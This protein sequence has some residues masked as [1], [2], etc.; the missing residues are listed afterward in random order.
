MEDV[1]ESRTL[2]VDLL[3]SMGLEVAEAADGATAVDLWENFAPHLIFMDIR[4]PVLDGYKATRQI[5][6]HPQ[7]ENTIIIAISASV[8]DEERERILAAGCNDFV[9]KPFSRSIIFDKLNE[10]LG[11]Q[12]VYEDTLDP[13]KL[14]SLPTEIKIQEGLVLMPKKWVQDFHLAARTADQEEM[15]EL[16]KEI[17]ESLDWLAETLLE[18]IKTF[19]LDQIIELMGEAM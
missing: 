9:A 14:P 1:A 4:L 6:A 13:V 18:L 16:L 11:I 5:R 8:F 2:L 15:F 3:T 7:G 12:Y 19:H 10:H 17:P